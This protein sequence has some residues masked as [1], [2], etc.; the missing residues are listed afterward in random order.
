[1]YVMLAV[2]KQTVNLLEGSAV[3]LTKGLPAMDFILSHFEAGQK[4][5]ENDA[6]MAPVYQEG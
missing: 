2:L 5:Y 3:G 1:M 4:K 6:I